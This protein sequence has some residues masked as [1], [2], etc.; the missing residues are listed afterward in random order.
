MQIFPTNAHGTKIT[1]S[2]LSLF[3]FA[4]SQNPGIAPNNNVPKN[5]QTSPPREWRHA[6]L[7]N[8]QSHAVGYLGSREARKAQI[9]VDFTGW[10]SKQVNM[11]CGRGEWWYTSNVHQIDHNPQIGW[12]APNKWL[13]G[14]MSILWMHWSFYLILLPAILYGAE[15]SHT[16][17]LSQSCSCLSVDN[18][19]AAKT[20]STSSSK[21]LSGIPSTL[22]TWSNCASS[23]LPQGPQEQAIN[24]TPRYQI[25][26]TASSICS[27]HKLQRQIHKNRWVLDR[28]SSSANQNY[29]LTQLWM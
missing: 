12:S 4:I 1:G 20:R 2:G 17:K 26:S 9:R 18:Q 11:W 5:T 22:I 7:R 8:M 15:Q 14:W 28:I 3:A 27:L 24:F 16:R 23:T 21:V 6:Y 19:A 29:T 13:C 25:T 10:W